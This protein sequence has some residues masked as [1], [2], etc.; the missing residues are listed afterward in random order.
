MELVYLWIKEYKNIKNQ[1]F[2]F[3]PKFECEYKNGN[4]T[5][6]D[7]K[8][9]DDNCK[10]KDYIENF[11]G[12]N[13]NI[14][15]IVG[16]NGS[17][18][19]NI[20]KALF[21]NDDHSSAYDELWY[22][23]YS[24]FDNKLNIYFIDRTG[25]KEKRDVEKNFTHN[26]ETL[27]NEAT[28][29]TE[30]NFSMVYF[31]NILHYLPVHNDK[32]KKSFYNISTSYLIDRYTKKISND[33]FIEF[34]YQY[35]Y[36]KSKIIEQTIIMLKDS[37]I[38]LDFLL[39]QDL[40]IVTLDTYPT[41]KIEIM[42]KLLKEEDSMDFRQRV[43]KNVIYNF[44][45]NYLDQDELFQR[46][47]TDDKKTIQ[48]FYEEIKSTIPL[49]DE[50]DDFLN[51]LENPNFFMTSVKIQDI[52]KEFIKKLKKFNSIQALSLGIL[53]V[54]HLNWKPEL[55]S[56]QEN[57]LFQFAS[58]YNLFKNGTNLKNDIVILIDEG[59]TT[60]H[61]NW[62]KKY[63]N[64]LHKFF[65][66]NFSDKQIHLIV[67]SHSPFILSDIPKENVIFLETHKKDDIE[68]KEASQQVGDCKNATKDININTFG[69]NIHTLLSNGFFMDD[70]LMGKFAKGKITEVLKYLNKEK[71]LKTIKKK[72]IKS[73]IDSIGEDFLRNKL[74]DLYYKKFNIKSKDDEIK[75]L[76][77]EIE[78]LKN[79]RN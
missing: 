4:L 68:V 60:M 62:Q 15:A 11:F 7:K 70:G 6:C 8:A 31:S 24:E 3:A 38:K 29:Q 1:G 42:E 10:S 78:R 32:Q 76:R 73:I 64:Y 77:E 65:K 66:N 58:F 75:E 48:E 34:K 55:S 36:Y 16:E 71:K 35:N 13:M 72:Q 14:T 18:K 22:I 17:G 5:I 43:K 41:D 53:D 45:F 33:K 79:D 21:Q 26:I 57:Y 39:P 40:N 52:D 19:S 2:N 30:L 37:E 61:P 46:I 25:I 54:F 59:E 49:A 23:L 56:G 20:L 12:K 63:I 67:S 51:L 28:L 44:L 69:A 50:L 47:T 27:K 74:L 9:K